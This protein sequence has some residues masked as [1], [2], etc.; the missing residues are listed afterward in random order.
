MSLSVLPSGKGH[1]GISRPELAYLW[2]G[3]GGLVV[4]NSPLYR[5]RGSSVERKLVYNREEAYFDIRGL[6]QLED[7]WRFANS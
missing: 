5:D 1:G 4:P 3:A 7:P 2:R 6:W